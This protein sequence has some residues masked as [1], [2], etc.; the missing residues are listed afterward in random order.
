MLHL[1]GNFLDNIHDF[2]RFRPSMKQIRSIAIA[3]LRSGVWL[4]VAMLTLLLVPELVAPVS[5]TNRFDSSDGLIDA[6][7]TL[8][9]GTIHSRPAINPA[10]PPAPPAS[11]VAPTYP[12]CGGQREF[13]GIDR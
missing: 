5:A 9:Y 8:S 2:A 7:I 11:P 4:G 10:T 13:E 6:Q 3:V 1:Q 12:L